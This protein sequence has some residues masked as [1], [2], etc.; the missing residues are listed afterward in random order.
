MAELLPIRNCENPSRR[1]D[2]IF[3]HGLNGN[4]RQ[5]WFPEGEPEK[6]WPAWLG[7][8]LPDV[9]VWSLGYE[10]A[11]LKP[12]RPSLARRFLA[13]GFAMPLFDRARNV[14]LR[15]ELE[16]LGARP[17]VFIT[18]SM[19][20]LLVK[21]VLNTASDGSN[22]GWKS[23][24]DQTR[25]V[26]FIAT[27]HIG[28]DLAKWASYFR[29][30]LGTNV[31]TEELRPHQPHLRHL[32][33][34][35]RDYLCRDDVN[36]KTLSFFEM[37]PMPGVGLVV[38]P[39]DADPGVP[40]AGLHPLDEDHVSICK[41]RSRQ[42]E[43]YVAVLRFVRD[44]CLPVPPGPGGSD[45]RPGSAGAMT[46]PPGEGHR[47]EGAGIPT[48]ARPGEA[49]PDTDPRGS[50]AQRSS[51]DALSE[52]LQRRLARAIREASVEIMDARRA[53][54][55]RLDLGE[56]RQFV[57]EVVAG[58][59]AE[60]ALMRRLD[61]AL[62]LIETLEEAIDFLRARQEGPAGL[63]VLFEPQIREKQSK[64]RDEYSTLRA[65]LGELVGGAFIVE[66]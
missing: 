22:P 35:Y 26:C 17:L 25:G 21:Q 52:T 15:L 13:A 20:G 57:A 8:D 31:S 38:D 2:V 23:I 48:A 7:E 11:A 54:E 39:G 60:R 46:S 62:Q 14:L 27:P 12:R 65:V 30:L 1:G 24:L 16:G 49:T 5:Y 40:R 6:S 28:S 41:P 34:W 53:P 10:N 4:P 59:V 56:G 47:G 37:K 55:V 29:S 18:H 3:V 50:G 51:L 9:G 19:G 43:I 33:Q 61:S 36:I 32:N 66:S 44:E 58:A 42:A 45:P 64:L 63:V